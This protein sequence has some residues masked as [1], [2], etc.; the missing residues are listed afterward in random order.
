MYLDMKTAYRAQQ[1]MKVQKDPPKGYRYNEAG[2][3]V[4]VDFSEFH[5]MPSDSLNADAIKK[6]ISMFKILV[7]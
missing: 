4:P 2:N 6:G 5:E 7:L 3:L 1:G